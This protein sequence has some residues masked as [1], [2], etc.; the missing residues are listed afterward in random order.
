[1]RQ[2]FFQAGKSILP[3]FCFSS[4]A[5]NF[6]EK[7]R[8]PR[9]GKSMNTRTLRGKEVPTSG[10]SVHAL[11][12]AIAFAVTCGMLGVA[13]SLA[14]QERPDKVAGSSKGSQGAGIYFSAEAR[15]KDVG[16]PI[17][18]GARPYSDKDEN[19]SSVKFGLWGSSFAFKLAVVKLESNDS[20]QKV[21]AF[22]KKALAKYGTVL[23]CS[24][25]SSEAEDKNEN[26]PSHQ[27]SC[28]NDKPKPRRN[29]LQGGN[30]GKTAYRRNPAERRGQH[31]PACLCR[32]AGL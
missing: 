16:L 24:A 7:M 9:T 20:P 29:D 2:L 8:V 3:A 28:E 15:A 1:L 19:Q 23:D 17:Y 27:I 10:K 11:R 21:S 5:G 32:V 30:E 14:A 12:A 26:K 13:L 22:Y 18:P 6:P 25:A 4:I 31:L